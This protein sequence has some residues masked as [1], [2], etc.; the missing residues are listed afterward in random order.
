MK[1]LLILFLIILPFT[2]FTQQSEIRGVIS[3][4]NSEYETGTRQYV[5][6]AQVEDEFEQANAQL[7]DANGAFNLIFSGVSENTSVSLIAKKEGLQVVN[8]DALTA[9]TGQRETVRLSM[10]KPNQIADYRREIY[11]VGRTQAEKTLAAKLKKT[12]AEIERLQQD[13][14]KN[15]VKIAQL[16]K[17]WRELQAYFDKIEAQAMDL[18][19]RYAPINLDDAAPLFREA[20]RLFQAGEL[21]QALQV[22]RGANLVHQADQ[23]LAEEKAIKEVQKELN[24]RDSIK[25][26]RKS[27]LMLA[28]GLKADLHKAKFEW[29]SVLFS[30]KLRVTLDSAD[31]NNIWDFAF[32]LAEQNQNDEAITYFEKAF[33]QSKT[34][35]LKAT[36]LNSLGVLYSLNQ[37]MPAAQKAYLEALDI[38]QR[39]AQKNP[40]QFLPDL[41]RTLNNL[42][43]YYRN[44]QNMPEAE[45]T[46]L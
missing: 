24:I 21:D 38:H 5:V 12:D 7:T 25:T 33:Y 8:L 23:I 19:R 18:A 11:Q 20:F 45:K 4:H 44:N 26:Q 41:A 9:V 2:G 1:H 16:Q 36:F 22:L 17:E 6:N 13:V 27:D 39:L 43:E 32:F 29:D 14:E 42:G 31:V 34:A 35:E 30:L 15:K 10:A 46:F 3:I 40:K 28:L 37:N